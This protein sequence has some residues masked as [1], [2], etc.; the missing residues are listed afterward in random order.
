MKKA[1]RDNMKIVVKDRGTSLRERLRER[2]EMAS[3]LRCKEHNE[4]VISVTIHEREN[5]WFDSVWTTCCEGLERRASAIVKA[6]C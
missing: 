5:G 6:R 4:P 2:L 1:L 3:L